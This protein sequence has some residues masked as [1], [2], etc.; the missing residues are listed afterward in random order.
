[1]TDQS[2]QNI[3]SRAT[4]SYTTV[5]WPSGV[6]SPVHDMTSKLTLGPALA[7]RK[8]SQDEL[9]GLGYWL[10]AVSPAEEVVERLNTLFSDHMI[11]STDLRSIYAAN[12]QVIQEMQTFGGA[13]HRLIHRQDRSDKEK[14]YDH[15][16]MDMCWANLEVTLQEHRRL[17]TEH[18]YVSLE[19]PFRL[20]TARQRARQE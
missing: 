14:L 5:R 4:G 13:M 8:I 3:S 18:G 11:A 6:H 12:R 16:L 10:D 15:H 9:T 17:W 7:D 19:T 1:M 20:A 2:S